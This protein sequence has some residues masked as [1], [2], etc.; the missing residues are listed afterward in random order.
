[1]TKQVDWTTCTDISNNK[2]ECLPCTYFINSIKQEYTQ[3]YHEHLSSYYREICYLYTCNKM[4]VYYYQINSQMQ[5]YIF[6]S[7]IMY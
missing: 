6:S 1:M 4:T 3:H 5:T 7:C 2:N